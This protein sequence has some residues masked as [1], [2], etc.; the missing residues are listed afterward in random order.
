VIYINPPTVYP[1]TFEQFGV[2]AASTLKPLF[3][4]D[5]WMCNVQL[6][7][8]GTGSVTIG[9]VA[10]QGY[11]ISS[12][13][14][15]VSFE[16]PLNLKDVMFIISSGTTVGLVVTGTPMTKEQIDWWLKHDTI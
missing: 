8:M 15:V 16:Y 11:L 1:K 2:L 14:T 7:L 6:R 10:N 3:A 9:D 12:T 4:Y 5:K 13:S